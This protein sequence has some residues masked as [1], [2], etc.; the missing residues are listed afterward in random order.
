[1]RQ[2]LLDIYQALFDCFGPQHWWPGETPLEILV[3]A[4][5]TQNT[6]WSNV[7]R[8]ID[9]LRRAGLLSLD[10]LVHLPTPLLAEQIRPSG[11]Y[12]LKAVRL[13]NLLHHIAAS[14]GSVEGYFD[15]RPTASLREELLAIKGIGPETADSILLYAGNKPTF[16]V[17]AYT[18]R[19]LNR[20]G[21]VADESDYHELQALFLDH[22][23]PDVTLFNEYHALIVRTAKEF[24]RKSNP[25]CDAC[26]LKGF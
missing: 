13:Q 22:L 3:G 18:H 11:Y 21:L 8:A 14:A 7:S 2:R 17:D 12:N 9:N 20:H 19:I 15:R 6:N 24:C 10:A 16:V 25:A 5:L 23:E 26:P 1:M 4:V